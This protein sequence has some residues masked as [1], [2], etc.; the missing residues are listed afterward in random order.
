MNGVRWVAWVG[1]LGL[2]G[3]YPACAQAP[4]GPSGA[5]GGASI[6]FRGGGEVGVFRKG[7]VL[8]TDRAYVVAECPPILEG[9]RFLRNSIETDPFDVIKPGVLFLLTPEPDH[10]RAS[11]QGKA[12]ES[13]GFAW[14][15]SPEKFQLF[16]AQPFDLTRIYR[17]EVLAGERFRLGKWTVVLGFESA[18]RRDPVVRPWG[19]NRGERLYNGIVLPE[20]WP[21]QEIDPKDDAPM[22]V[23]YLEHP[24]AVIPIDVGRQLLVD[25][26]L[27]QTTTLAR[28]FHMP[29][30]YGRNPVL[31]PETALERPGTNNAVAAPKSGGLWWDPHEKVFKLWYEAGWIHTIAYATSRDGLAWDRPVL[32]VRPGSNQVLP[33]DL[34][35]DSWTVV[36]DWDAKDPSRRYVMRMQPPGKTQPGLCMTSADGIHWTNRF[37]TGDAGDRSTLFFNPFRGTWVHSIRSGFRGRSRHYWECGEFPGDPTWQAGEPAVWA[38]ADRDDP[39]DPAIGDKAQLYNLDAVAYE[40]LMLGMFEIHRGPANDVCM[41]LGLPKITELSFAYSRDGF[42]WHRPDRRAHIPAERRDVWDRGY[43]QSLGNV[44][45]IVGDKLFIYYSG[46]RGDTNRVSGDWMQNGMYH[47]GATGVAFLRRDGFASLDAGAQPGVLLTRPVTFSGR[48]LFVNLAAP[49]GTLRVEAQDADGKPIAPFTLANCEPLA[50]DATLAPVTWKGGPDL[51]ALAGRPVRF[52]FE[53][54]SGSLYAFWVSRDETGRSDGYVAGG[55][56]GYTGPTDT[57]GRAVLR[58]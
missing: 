2:L 27:V 28:T 29:V 40:S 55:G 43:V 9:L 34:K 1:V 58:P 3:A 56:P 42:H 47:E 22:R 45:T 36:P 46:F 18:E 49:Q 8:F 15:K 13:R 10:P 24:P 54:T 57:V 35:P 4:G 38:A 7:E 12:L 26:F 44:C 50:G 48:R 32:D 5:G 23:P 6:A 39:P 41:K 53:L 37:W 11:T 14:V 19:E 21:P 20:E 16:G 30:K 33:A 51:S 52:L 17:K 25:D 31:K